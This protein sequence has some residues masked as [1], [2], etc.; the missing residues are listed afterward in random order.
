MNI[1]LQC[2]GLVMLLVLLLTIASERSPNSQTRKRFYGAILT[3]ILCLSLDIASLLLMRFS[4]NGGPVPEIVANY[5]RKIYFVSLAQQA[6]QAF[7]YC[8]GTFF[9]ARRH[10]P[11]RLAYSIVYMAGAILIIALPM[12]FSSSGTHFFASGPSV[13]TSS[14]V[15]GIYI[16]S[17]IAMAFINVRYRKMRRLSIVAWQACWIIAA[18]LQATTNA[19]PLVGFAAAFGIVIVY[20]EL[21]SP[22]IY[23]DRTTNLFNSN[24]FITYTNDM[25]AFKK[26][27]ASI[28]YTLHY[29]SKDV[30]PSTAAETVSSIAALLN[31]NMEA[32]AFE[33]DNETITV[34]YKNG[35]KALDGDRDF[36]QKVSES[37]KTPLKITAIY[38][39]DSLMLNNE[40]DFSRLIHHCKSEYPN[41]DF[42]EIDEAI[43]KESKRSDEVIEMID[44]AIKE[45]RVLVYYQPIYNLKKGKFVSAEALVRIKGEDGQLIFPGSFIPEAERSG[46]ISELSEVIFTKVC[47]FLKKGEAISLGLEYV[48]VNLSVAEFDQDN[49]SS[50]IIRKLEEYGVD[51]KYLNFEI[52][53][54]AESEAKSLILK[55]MNA[56]LEKGVSFSLDDFGTGRSNLDYFVDMPVSV[57]KFDHSFTRRY[58]ESDKAKKMLESVCGF[59]SGMGL[60]VVAEGVETQE[61]FDSI[62]KLGVTSIQG[63]YFSKAIDE[64]SFIEFLKKN[65][66]GQ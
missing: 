50:F 11:L 17:S 46:Q 41:E 6:Y 55:N 30:D 31:Q 58:F 39:Q 12:D 63:Y 51:G 4:K 5:A 65:N 42:I 29:L 7:L 56:L 3:C 54:T 20:M 57:I 27:F 59:M 1:E 35:E 16:A 13:I 62:N 15:I 38:V 8:A 60:S 33:N 66:K 44:K 9:A 37:L 26:S 64:D 25:Y 45:D 23:L 48:E 43:L 47:E 24:A 28:T 52:T 53:E 19:I 18:I 22:H 14:I 10:F 49:P 32:L 61:Q 21:E 40:M 2:C 34:I 36:M